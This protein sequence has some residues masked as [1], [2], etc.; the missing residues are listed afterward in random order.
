MESFKTATGYVP[1]IIGRMAELHGRYYAANWNFGSFFEAKVATGLSDF[2]ARYNID[3]DCIWSVVS[4]GRI[5][6]GMAI[7]G[8][9][10]S[11][12]VAHLRWFIMSESIRGMGAGNL[13]MEQA[14]EFCRLKG[15]RTVYLWTFQGLIPARH[16]Y[17]K[18]G[19][20]QVEELSG[21][22]WGT[23]VVEQ[24]FERQF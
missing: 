23:V 9:N 14:M 7:D 2:I 13:L 1:G 24:R 17:E 6:G 4:G 16:L 5:Q 18:F 8:T 15:Y 22:Q 10:E 3:K 19:F 21:D 12:G 20:R 11:P